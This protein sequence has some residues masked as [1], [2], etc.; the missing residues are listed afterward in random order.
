M[1]FFQGETDVTDPSFPPPTA[2]VT[3]VLGSRRPVPRPPPTAAGPG[4]APR[5]PD[6]DPRDRLIVVW[7]SL[8]YIIMVALVS[9]AF[10]IADRVVNPPPPPKGCREGVEGDCGE[11]E[12]CKDRSC[13]PLDTALC[14][15]GDPC[16]AC[17]C[18]APS[19]CG[20]DSICRAPVLPPTT[21]CTDEMVKFVKEIVAHQADCIATT[22]GK[23][24]SQCSAG[25]VE[26]FLLAHERFDALLKDFPN[27]LVFMF[28]SGEPSTQSEGNDGARSTW[29]IKPDGT[30][31]TSYDDK[32]KEHAAVLRD[33]RHIIV[34]GRASRTLNRAADD[35]AMA[36]SRIRFATDALLENLTASSQER[37][38]LSSKILEF[39]VG[40]EQKLQLEFYA[41]HYRRPTV[42]WSAT[43]PVEL[44]KAL[45]KLET[46]QPVTALERSKAELLINR[47]V[48]IFAVPAECVR[49]E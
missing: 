29:L 9:S 1:K 13:V 38:A 25:N 6:A 43:A 2:A 44:S 10:Y 41:A 27:S 36:Q 31:N 45:R 7:M 33:A 49:S 40:S 47:S 20:A 39:A 32:V 19:L 15:E 24:L 46:N 4:S 21:V 11:G 3:Q 35:Y 5:S 30:T 16:G 22:G 42:W 23:S 37:E 26:S 18:L 17:T 8:G 12:Y 14:K 34:V 28:P 48:A